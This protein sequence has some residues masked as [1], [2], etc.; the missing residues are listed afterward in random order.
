MVW[1]TLPAGSDVAAVEQAWEAE[2]E[3]MTSHFFDERPLLDNG[4]NYLPPGG[5]TVISGT[6]VD[7]EELSPYS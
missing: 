1:H 4:T 6:P 2:C 5:L 3:H 7:V